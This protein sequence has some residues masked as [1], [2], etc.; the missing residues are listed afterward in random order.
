M[1]APK[2]KLSD[3]RK[4]QIASLLLLTPVL[5]WCALAA[6]GAAGSLGTLVRLAEVNTVG[7]ELEGGVDVV[8]DDERRPESAQAPPARRDLVGRAL[9]SQ[10]NDRRARNDRPPRSVD[11][12]DDRVH[13]HATSARPSSVAGSRLASAS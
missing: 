1:N 4:T 8:V 3:A 6:C 7:A 5:V 13:P 2:N 10:L 11:I 12:L 9:H